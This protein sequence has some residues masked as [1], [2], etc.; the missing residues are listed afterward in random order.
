MGHRTILGAPRRRD[1]RTAVAAIEDHG[2]AIS[3]IQA[4]RAEQASPCLNP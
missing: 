3:G 1:V 2:R 4:T